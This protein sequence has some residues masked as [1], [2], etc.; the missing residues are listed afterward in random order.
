M[1]VIE[2][3]RIVA[4]YDQTK[5][6]IGL[7]L[8][9]ADRHGIVAQNEK[10]SLRLTD[11]RFIL[12]SELPVDPA[13]LESL[14]LFQHLVSEQINILEGQNTLSLLS[15]LD[16]AFDL[17]TACAQ[18]GCLSDPQ[19]FALLFLLRGHPELFQC[20]KGMYQAR[21][22]EER[23]HLLERL[24]QEQERA[25]YLVKVKEFIQ[26]SPTAFSEEERFVLSRE[27]R[28][29]LMNGEPKD[30][31]KLIRS[32]LP[33]QTLEHSILQLRLR[34]GDITPATDPIA[35]QSGIPVCFPVTLADTALDVFPP[36]NTETTAFSIDNPDTQDH[37]D[38]ISF[39]PT[40]QGFRIG[41]HISDVSS[42][43][44]KSSA[45]Y[46]EARERV[47]SLYLTAQTIPMLPEILS[48]SRFSLVQNARHPV[49]S[50]Y[51]E[52]NS[53]LKIIER[54]FRRESILISRNLF[55]N[56]VDSQLQEEPFST[57]QRFVRIHRGERGASGNDGRQRYYWMLKKRG[58]ELYFVREDSQS[59]ARIIVEELMVLYNRLLAEQAGKNTL[60]LIYR[61]IQ[62]FEAPDEE[63]GGQVYGAQAYL[64][65]EGKFH[66]GIGSA[67]Y[68]HATSPIRRFTDIVNQ[69]Q[70]MTLLEG[71]EQQYSQAELEE[72]IP[73][74]EARL[75]F[76]RE[77]SRKSER[78]WL[79]KYLEQK[80]LHEPLD[81]VVLRKVREGYL[82]ELTRWEKKIVLRCEDSV[83]LDIPV[84]AV[85]SG[86]DPDELIAQG[87]IVY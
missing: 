59:P 5:L 15:E 81:A 1:S 82:I 24:R 8:E 4:F 10:E 84:K 85:I 38:A 16:G 67:A 86:V 80:H 71:K 83:P 20:K 11:D 3:G 58:D 35:E 77:I 34:L 61:N 25:E 37:D 2:P 60:P 13:T 23:I 72:L 28:S 22:V 52:V 36:E 63:E 19:R 27:L 51:L 18:T 74:I 41:I 44:D 53:D 45:L 69:G 49:L 48:S 62:L 42:R 75:L 78:Y 32:A 73:R 12:N 31:G 26:D 50:L 39:V 9:T 57:L 64:S 21:S 76:L 30:L 87:D 56:D 17:D 6:C 46:A 14:E 55:Y 40:D 66:P 33:E 65:T 79:L 43:L 7:I 54:S 29:L 47:S 68:L 70:F